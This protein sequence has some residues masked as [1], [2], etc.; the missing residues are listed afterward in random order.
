MELELHINI[1]AHYLVKFFL[2]Y[3]NNLSGLTLI[4]VLYIWNEKG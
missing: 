2:Q 3:K 1:V 4:T